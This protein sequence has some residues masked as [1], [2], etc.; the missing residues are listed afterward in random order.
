MHFATKPLYTS[1]DID[2][3]LVELLFALLDENPSNRP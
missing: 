3:N 2:P 1:G